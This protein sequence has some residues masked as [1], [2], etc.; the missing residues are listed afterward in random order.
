MFPEIILKKKTKLKID[1]INR[2]FNFPFVSVNLGGM[3]VFYFSIFDLRLTLTLDLFSFDPLR[4]YLF[5]SLYNCMP[6]VSMFVYV[7]VVPHAGNHLEIK[8]SV[9]QVHLTQAYIYIIQ[10]VICMYFTLNF[11]YLYKSFSG[12]SYM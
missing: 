6:F 12:W 11:Y 2:Y 7:F 10:L 4:E 1:V 9:H 5:F 3:C 8:T